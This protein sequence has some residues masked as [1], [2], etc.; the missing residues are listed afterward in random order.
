MNKDDDEKTM[1]PVQPFVRML[2][3]Q[4]GPASADVCAPSGRA[5]LL[6]LLFQ[7]LPINKSG[8]LLFFR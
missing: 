6:S 8:R 2:V 4:L 7:R 5:E 3:S 1:I